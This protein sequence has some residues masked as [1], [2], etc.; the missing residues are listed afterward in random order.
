MDNTESEDITNAI[1]E[2]IDQIE[3]DVRYVPKYGGEVIALDPNDD[4]KFVGG[5]FSYKDHVSLEFSEGSLFDDPDKFLEGKGKSRR[6]LK[7]MSVDDVD[8]KGTRRF[9][10]QALEP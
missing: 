5:I 2:I 6:H 3:P 7:F 1:K 4:S 10:K 8:A 9:L